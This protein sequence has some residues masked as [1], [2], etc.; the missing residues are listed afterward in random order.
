MKADFYLNKFGIY[1]PFLKKKP[2][3]NLGLVVVIPAYNEVHLEQSLQALLNCQKPNC[4]T[5]IIVV[6]NAGENAPAEVINNNLLAAKMINELAQKSP[7]SIRL[8]FIEVNQLPSKHAGVGLARKIGMDEAVRR[9]DDVNNHEGLIVCF[10]ADSTCEENY[11]CEIFNHF[12]KNPKSPA[13]SIHFEHPLS[14]SEFSAEVYEAIVD[15]E[16]HL[17]YY[18]EGLRYAGYPYSFHT[19]G[20]SMAVRSK[21]YQQ[22][23]GMNKR[24]A[25]EDF[26]FLHKIIPL[27][28]FTE[29]NTTKVIPSPR[30]SDRVPFGT[31]RAV[32]KILA[33]GNEELLT[34]NPEIFEELKK[35]LKQVYVKKLHLSPSDFSG[36][37]KDF[38]LQNDFENKIE[39]IKQ[40]SSTEEKFLK[41][42]FSWMD[43]FMVLKLVHFLRDTT[44]PELPIKEAAAELLFMK[45]SLNAESLS[46]IDLLEHY[47]RYQRIL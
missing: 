9:F 2:A 7:E 31:G 36:P 1:P 44:Y 33:G 26:Y 20:S 43:G 18:I 34:Y 4:S 12:N 8:F 32:N 22:Q 6:I 5:E 23:G 41:R 16:L 19:I 27:G 3:E 42:F 45:Y 21:I 47:R 11:L 15:Y 39:E 35:I 28:N 38:L 17:R 25:G 24:K 40:N 13:C 14:G 29:I 30:P 10:D 46:T 37:V